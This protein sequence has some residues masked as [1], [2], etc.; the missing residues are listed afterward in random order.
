MKKIKNN[1]LKYP[2]GEIISKGLRDIR[3]GKYNSIESL[4]VFM[5]SPRLNEFGFHIDENHFIYPHL[6]LYKKLQKKYANSA[7]EQYNAVMKRVAK[8]CNHY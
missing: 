3:H 6:L 8:F 2:G 4:A 5:A 7:H 1:L